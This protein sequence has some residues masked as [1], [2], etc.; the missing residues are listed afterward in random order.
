M[1]T[2]NMADMTEVSRRLTSRG[3]QGVASDDRAANA[4]AFMR[5]IR[6]QSP[7]L[8]FFAVQLQT[9]APS[10][11]LSHL[12]SDLQS[13]SFIWLQSLVPMQAHLR[14]PP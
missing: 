4:A 5:S 11:A 10:S 1:P 12:G 13:E 7:V 3:R 14:S 6:H 2:L 9:M 8:E